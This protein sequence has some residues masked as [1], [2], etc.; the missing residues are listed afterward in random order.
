MHQRSE[1]TPLTALKLAGLLNEAGFPPCVANIVNGY[2]K[3][4]SR[5]DTH[6][7]LIAPR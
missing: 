5:K 7:Y 2:G 4:P 1:L 3:D 6:H